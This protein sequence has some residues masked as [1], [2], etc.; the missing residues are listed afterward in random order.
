MF[1]YA[2][3]SKILCMYGWMDEWMQKSME[4]YMDAYA[5]LLKIYAYM[6]G[7]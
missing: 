6:N 4:G 1:E 5:L 7:C 3:L 2:L